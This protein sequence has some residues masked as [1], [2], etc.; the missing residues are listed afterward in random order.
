MI[1][2]LQVI[3][4]L[5]SAKGIAFDDC[6]KI[7]ILMDD[8]QVAKMREYEYETLFTSDQLTKKDMLGKITEWFDNSCGLRFVSAVTTHEDPNRGFEDIIAQGECDEDDD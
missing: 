8:Q 6:H 7:Y 3:E 4:A 5:E 1:K 2:T